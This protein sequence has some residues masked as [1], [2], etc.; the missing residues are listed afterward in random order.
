ML[1]DHM[2]SL[3]GE[4]KPLPGHLLGGRG[5]A[6]NS[7]RHACAA[8]LEG[9][10][11]CC[12]SAGSLGGAG[13]ALPGARRAAA[14]MRTCAGAGPHLVALD[15]DGLALRLQLH[16]HRRV[17]RLDDAP[18]VPPA[19]THRPSAHPSTRVMRPLVAPARTHR[20]SAPS[21]TT[22]WSPG[23]PFT[24]TPKSPS[25]AALARLEALIMLHVEQRLLPAS[26]SS[27]QHAWLCV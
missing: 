19:R 16:A 26:F 23:T 9:P 10:Q 24:A 4:R 17:G 27:S 3:P 22:Q 2:C 6:G 18:L 20:H 13:T 12:C 15:V 1:F 7:E 21:F 14:C 5:P 25:C 11:A 8:G